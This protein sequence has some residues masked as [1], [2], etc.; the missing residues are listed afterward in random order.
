MTGVEDILEGRLTEGFHL[1]QGDG[2][3]RRDHPGRPAGA[4][5]ARTQPREPEVIWGNG[6]KVTRY[7]DTKVTVVGERSSLVRRSSRTT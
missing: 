5:T 6:Q 2:G 1:S 7:F 3:R 4:S